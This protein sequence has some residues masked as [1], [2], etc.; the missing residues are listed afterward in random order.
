M[1]LAATSAESRSEVQSLSHDV[2]TDHLFDA[3]LRFSSPQDEADFHKRSAEAQK[4]IDRQLARHTPEGDLNADGG[5]IGEMLDLHAHGAGSSPDFMPRW[6]SLVEKAERQRA[7]MRA[8]GQ[9]TDEFDRNLKDSV[10]R[11]LKAKGLSDA[12]IDQRL[13]ATDDPLKLV[14]PYMAND[15]ASRKLEDKLDLTT[16]RTTGPQSLPQVVASDETT[17]PAVPQT[18]DL[19]AISARLKAH[20]VQIADNGSSGHG[21]YVQKPQPST[22]Q[23]ITG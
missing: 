19:D 18:S 16:Q 15:D 1:S 9:S 13:A 12:E 5:M 10:R 7:A 14:K 6:N 2:F 20:G 11:F 22:G 3:Y 4:Y 8:N 17:T 23:G 21:L